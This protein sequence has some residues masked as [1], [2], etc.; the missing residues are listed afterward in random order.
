MAVADFVRNNLVVAPAG[1][2]IS[3]INKMGSDIWH[4]GW[5]APYR[6]ERL[7]RDNYS[8]MIINGDHRYHPYFKDYTCSG[9]FVVQFEDF[10]DRFLELV[11]GKTHMEYCSCGFYAYYGEQEHQ[12][13]GQIAGVIE[14]YG[15]TLVGTQGFRS[16]KARILAL[17][18]YNHYQATYDKK[19]G[20]LTNGVKIWNPDRVMRK[21]RRRYEGVMVFDTVAEMHEAFPP[22]TAEEVRV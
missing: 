2:Q 20:Y 14:G 15:E 19:P 3:S 6:Y 16:E 7:I 11:K 9:V 1:M 12:Y 5:V 13:N 10:R 21:L 4:V 17:A 22:T 8:D 18:P